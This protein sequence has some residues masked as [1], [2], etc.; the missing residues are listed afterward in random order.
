MQDQIETKP[1]WLKEAE[2]ATELNVSASWLQKDRG[3]PKPEIP[4]KRF[5]RSVRYRSE[6]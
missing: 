6:G 3:K 4:F 2:K 1:K 5:G